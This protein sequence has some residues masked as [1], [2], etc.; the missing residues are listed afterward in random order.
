MSIIEGRNSIWEYVIGLEIHAQVDSK[1][2]LF[3]CASTDF[4]SSPNA[5]VAL[6]DAAFPGT[7]PVLNKFCVEQAVKT[8]LAINGNI[9]KKS[10]FDRKNYFYADLPSG[11]QISQ[12]YHPIIQGG[13][14][15]IENENGIAKKIEIHQ[16]HLEQDAGKSM[17]DQSPNYSFVDLNRAGVALMEIVSCPDLR[18]PFE[19]GEY[20]KKLRSI[21]R[22]IGTCDGNMEQGSLRIDANVSVRK[23]GEPLGT[24]CEIKN[25]NS[26]KNVIRA[27]EYE[28]MR[29]VEILESGGTIEQET[30][31]FNADEGTTRTMRSKENALDYRYFPDP[32]IPPVVL[33]DEFIESIRKNLPE[34]PDQKIGRYIENLGL[35]EYDAKL[36]A[37]DID[38]SKYF[39]E[40]ASTSNDAKLSANWIISELFAY[41]KQKDLEINNSNISS[42][43]LGKLINLITQGKISGKIAKQIFEI[44]QETGEDPSLIIEKHGLVQISDDAYIEELI[45]KILQ[46]NKS[47]VEEYK[48]GKTKLFGFFVG[49]IMKESGGKV[50]PSIAN[51]ILTR[52]LS[53]N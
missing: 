20:I 14:V 6:F 34:L 36:L 44:M 42:I 27:I 37:A 24:R 47:S 2:K 11:Y 53:T 9:N 41:L 38:V 23:P 19:A 3:S 45:K 52:L 15:E 30:R 50:N 49:Q 40:V 29:Q 5:N 22:A 17:H 51:D 28:A 26:I 35:S 32:D 48:K 12:F 10:I 16:I 18:S 31:L 39:E 21:L 7:L 43:Y 4:G 13:F 1:S 25:V 46:A 8:G 33:T